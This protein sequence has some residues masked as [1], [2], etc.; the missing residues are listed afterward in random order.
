MN[1]S[2]SKRKTLAI[3]LSCIAAGALAYNY[4]YIPHSLN[5]D[6]RQA[7][8]HAGIA[9]TEFPFIG[10]TLDTLAAGLAH[11]G[12]FIGESSYWHIVS[13][14]RAD[15]FNSDVGALRFLHANG[16][17]LDGSP[18]EFLRV[19]SEKVRADIR[20]KSTLERDNFPLDWARET[21]ALAN[22]LFEEGL[23]L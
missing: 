7:K 20:S 2:W 14:S 4:V 21:V 9:K 5:G 1:R 19:H 22:Q 18:D 10:S 15:Q 6:L 16:F 3:G 8:L 13:S 17:L 11:A 12:E 23:S